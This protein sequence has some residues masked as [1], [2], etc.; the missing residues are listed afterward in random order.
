MEWLSE[1]TAILNVIILAVQLILIWGQLHLSRKINK[2]T[3][4][5]E[6]GYFL[7]SETNL[8]HLQGEDARYRDQFDL[9]SPIGFYLTGGS[10]VIIRGSDLSIDGRKYTD[11]M[12]RNVYFTLDKRANRFLVNLELKETELQKDYI[13]VDFY[14]RLKNPYGY[15]YIEKTYT[16]FRK[17]QECDKTWTLE[18]YNIIFEGK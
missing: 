13:D 11:A 5:R 16:R 10:D 18:R 8:P 17:S 9:S 3:L 4:S 2:Q 7:L 14:F 1:N 6:K 12:P 15:N